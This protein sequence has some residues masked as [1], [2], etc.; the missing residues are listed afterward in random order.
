MTFV[1]GMAVGGSLVLA[2]LHMRQGYQRW[3]MQRHTNRCCDSYRASGG[4][5]GSEG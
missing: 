5:N 2:V 4:E 3:A 1:L